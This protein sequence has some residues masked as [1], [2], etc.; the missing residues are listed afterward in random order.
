MENTFDLKKFL[1]ENKLTSNS[2]ILAEAVE[3][4]HRGNGATQ[5]ILIPD[6]IKVEV[7]GYDEATDKDINTGIM[8]GAQQIAAA[9]KGNFGEDYDNV[10]LNPGAEY[11][12]GYQE[13]GKTKYLI[14]LKLKQ[15][16]DKLE[17]DPAS[18]KAEQA[19]QD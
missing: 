1:V 4:Q 15:V 7:M 3:V 14:Y 6:N 12:M 18:V 19:A 9:M 17:V 10:N 13:G 11:T 5:I 2:R 16:G 8:V